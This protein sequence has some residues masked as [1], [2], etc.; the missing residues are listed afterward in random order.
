M[1]LVDRHFHDQPESWLS[2]S[3]CAGLGAILVFVC[4]SSGYLRSC[5]D[6]AEVNTARGSRIAL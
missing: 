2:V 6:M 1:P 4:I 3:H 5:K